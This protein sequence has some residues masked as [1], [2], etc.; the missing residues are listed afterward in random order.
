MT[1]PGLGREVGATLGQNRT[2]FEGF[3]LPRIL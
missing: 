3:S 1:V 2:L